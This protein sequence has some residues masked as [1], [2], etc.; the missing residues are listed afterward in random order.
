MDSQ[1]ERQI[2]KLINMYKDMNKMIDC[3]IKRQIDEWMDR[4]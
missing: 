2:D 1:L 4:C 3:E